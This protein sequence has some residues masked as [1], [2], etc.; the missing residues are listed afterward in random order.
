MN[1]SPKLE[2]NKHDM[3]AV[4]RGAILAVGGAVLAYLS[5]QVIPNIDESTMLGAL[6]AGVASTM[7]NALRKYLSDTQ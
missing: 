5:T 3:L 7:L 4:L 6:V 2:L 1:G